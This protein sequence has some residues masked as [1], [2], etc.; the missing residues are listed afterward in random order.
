MQYVNITFCDITWKRHSG[1]LLYRN[2]LFLIVLKRY[3]SETGT[4]PKQFFLFSA[5]YSSI[6]TDQLIQCMD[7]VVVVWCSGY[8]YCTTL[9]NKA[10]TQVLRKHKF[11]SR[12]V[13]YSRWWGLWQR[14][15]L[16]IRL[17]A[18]RRST[19]Q[20]KLFII[21]IIYHHYGEGLHRPWHLETWHKFE[22][23]ISDSLYE[24]MTNKD[25]MNWV[26]WLLHNL[27]IRN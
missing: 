1:R 19:V 20:R 6:G 5:R 16:E 2:S 26:M 4:Q 23:C 18:F 7:L 17:N 13:G 12:C 27:Q 3:H 25:V 24:M 21:I 11:C 14:S 9:F 22:I 10:W 15:R 8:H